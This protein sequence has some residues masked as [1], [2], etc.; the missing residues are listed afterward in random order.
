MCPLVLEIARLV[1]PECV[2]AAAAFV[3]VTSSA[4]VTAPV[5]PSVVSSCVAAVTFSVPVTFA[6]P[7]VSVMMS[8]SPLM[9]IWL[10]VNLTDSTST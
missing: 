6:A 10:S 2:K 7:D 1:G 4:S 8:V 3:I 5:T 9:P